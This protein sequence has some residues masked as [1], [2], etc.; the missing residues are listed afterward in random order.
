MWGGPHILKDIGYGLS[1]Q[2]QTAVDILVPS[3][4]LSDIIGKLTI[5]Y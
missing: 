5:K 4:C 1:Q 2:A 3:V